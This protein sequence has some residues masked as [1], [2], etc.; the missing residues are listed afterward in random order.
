[1]P[2]FNITDDQIKKMVEA[3]I[4][5]SVDKLDEIKDYIPKA[6]FNEINERLK[7]S[8]EKISTYENQLKET[9]DLINNNKELKAQYESLNSKYQND[10]A[11]KNKENMNIS[12]KFMIEGKLRNEGAKHPELLM[13]LFN[14][15]E[16]SVE[17]NNL[18]G[19]DK[20]LETVRKAYP[21]QF[22]VKETDNNSGGA[23]NGG[24]TGRDGDSLD[25][26]DWESEL[27][28]IMGI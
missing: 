27:K 21:D 20:S 14:L 7:A 6:R 12:K 5:E 22:I 18:L 15:D 24:N 8:N 2:I 25:N 4:I 10:I 3:K 11:E 28:G 13:Q 9:S 19:F 17:N 16:I 26:I 1:M 23:G